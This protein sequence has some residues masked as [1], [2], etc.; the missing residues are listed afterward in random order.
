M[1]ADLDRLIAELD[2]IGALLGDNALLAS[3]AD[4]LRRQLR[5]LLHDLAAIGHL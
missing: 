4:M 1:T 3:T 2:G 5:R